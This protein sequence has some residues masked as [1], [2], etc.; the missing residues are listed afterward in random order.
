[1][2]KR[3]ANRG[4]IQSVLRETGFSMNA[5]ELDLLHIKRKFLVFLGA[6][7]TPCSLLLHLCRPLVQA[8]A[9]R[10]RSNKRTAMDL[11]R[12]T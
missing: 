3:F 1:M 8:L 10:L 7:S 9:R 4:V 11:R 6:Q 5:C 12:Y 2:K